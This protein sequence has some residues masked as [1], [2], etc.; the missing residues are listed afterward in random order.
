MDNSQNID[1]AI[2]QFVDVARRYCAWVE[3]NPD[4]PLTEMQRARR[5]LTELHLA[6]LSLPDIGVGEEVEAR[7]VPAEAWKAVCQRFSHLPV[8]QYWDVFDPLKLEEN[9]PVYWQLPDDLA[10]IYRDLKDNLNLFEAGHIVEAVWEWRFSFRTHWGQHLLGAQRA[11]HS[12]LQ[13][14][15]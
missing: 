10:D 5:L 3:S 14:E 6:A 11:L 8:N 15:E 2:M 4:E 1:P 12:Y 9:D 13:Y 7:E